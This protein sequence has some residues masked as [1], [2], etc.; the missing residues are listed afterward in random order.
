MCMCIVIQY[1]APFVSKVD[2]NFF[3]AK[4]I[5]NP[6]CLNGCPHYFRHN[7]LE[8]ATSMDCAL[9][10][11]WTTHNFLFVVLFDDITFLME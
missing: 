7:L 1:H 9:P 10:E 8:D 5:L 11:K 3:S 6:N 4:A 2:S